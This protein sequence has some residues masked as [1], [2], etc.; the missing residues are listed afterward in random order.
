M[1]RKIKR[2]VSACV[3]LVLV[4][5]MGGLY[6]W[7]T[8]VVD[9]DEPV[10]VASANTNVR[11][12]LR[13]ES[14]VSTVRFYADETQSS[15][16]TY[17][18]EDGHLRWLIDGGD[19]YTL[20]HHRVQDKAR[21]AWMLT[22]LDTAHE[23]TS[24]IN[25]SDF[26]LDPPALTVYVTYEDGSEHVVRV[27]IQSPDLRYY[28][29]MIDDDPAMYLISSFVAERMMIGI[30]DMLDV[31]FPTFDMEFVEY[32]RIARRDMPE[33]VIGLPEGDEGAGMI[34]ALLQS[35]GWLL[36]MHEP[37]PGLGISHWNLNENVLNPF[38]MFSIGE[39]V[40][41]HPESLEPFGLHE[42]LMEFEYRGDFGEVHL[43]FG[44]RFIYE[45]MELVYVMFADR[46]HVFK[47]EVWPA[48]PLID[49][50]VISIMERFVALVDIRDVYMLTIDSEDPSKVFELVVNHSPE[51]DTNAIFP[52][53]N[54]VPMEESDFRVLYRVFI[55]TSIDA[56]IEPFMP[57]GAPE[58]TITYH[59]MENP[60]TEVRFFRYDANFFTVS[61]D[62]Q[63]A[64]Y[65]T[66]QRHITLL[67][68]H[69]RGAV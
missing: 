54:G 66:N 1:S 35:P 32:I 38:T 41:L 64:W 61:V 44:D 11:L 51:E 28:F 10:E 29:V 23:D 27:G 69:L 20:N 42:P 50:N 33:I 21:V 59:R 14:E 49:V 48:L 15:M 46:P 12:I 60:N 17:V 47:S 67:F 31:S 37:F 58:F 8:R 36:V 40:E 68:E 13:D 52:T 22:A 5:V 34:D 57:Q 45:D 43:I 53:V 9:A 30:G 55:S 62:G 6:F 4:V 56:D 19:E 63:E 65:V 25:L 3:V 26:G 2:I 18:N 24:G 7:Q 39:L 16:T